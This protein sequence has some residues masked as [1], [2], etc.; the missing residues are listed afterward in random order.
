[1]F[2]LF[3]G[4]EKYISGPLKTRAVEALGLKSGITQFTVGTTI[5]T[6]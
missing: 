6:T 2:G 4:M 1:M 5:L 3:G